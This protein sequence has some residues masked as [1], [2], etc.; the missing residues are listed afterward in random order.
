M[1]ATGARCPKWARKVS[2][3]FVS[4]IHG[5]LDDREVDPGQLNGVGRAQQAGLDE[6]RRGQRRHVQHAAGAR[7]PFQCVGHRRVGELHHEG[8][9]RADLLDPQRRLERVDLV[10]LHADHR[11]GPR[12]A[13]LL[14]SLAPVGVPSDM[15]DTPV[16]QGPPAAGIGV[17]VDHHDLGAAEGELLHGAQPHALEA[18][19][20]HMALHVLGVHAIHQRMLS[21]RIG[22]K[23]A[24]ALNVDVPAQRGL[25][26]PWGCS[27]VVRAGDS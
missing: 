14:E 21:S 13:G 23:V 8:Q 25:E 24:A 2:C 20:D 7:D 10:D 1:I 19:D 11:G 26:P 4:R 22:A 9:V 3:V 17:V 16:V 27:S 18:A 5:E 6:G 15:G 12:Q